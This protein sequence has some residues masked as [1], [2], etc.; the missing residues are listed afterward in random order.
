MCVN[1]GRGPLVFGRWFLAL[2]LLDPGYTLVWGCFAFDAVSIRLSRIP[3][4]PS[5]DINII[6]VLGANVC[7]GMWFRCISQIAL[8]VSSGPSLFVNGISI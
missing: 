8:A 6:I 5:Q 1:A 2:G 7:S 3:R 4:M